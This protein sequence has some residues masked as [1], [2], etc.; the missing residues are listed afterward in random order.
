M[1]QILAKWYFRN[2][3]RFLMRK[4]GNVWHHIWVGQLTQA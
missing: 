2:L 3:R 4:I 1:G